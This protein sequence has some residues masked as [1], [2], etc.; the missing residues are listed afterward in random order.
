MDGTK[1]ELVGVLGGSFNPVHMGHMMLASYLTQWGYVDKVWMMLS[2]LNPLKEGRTMLPDLKRM[3]MINMATHNATDIDSCDIEL[4]MPRPS[5]TIDTLDLLSKR[6]PTK[7]FKLIIGS[8]N[9]RIFDRW[10]EHQR[11]L[12]EY[13]V[14]V[15]P[16]SGYP[17]D[18]VYVDGMEVVDAPI[19]NISSTFI[20]D[21][22]ARGKD[23]SFFLPP[24]VF[25]YI[26]ENRFYMPE[27]SKK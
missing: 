24:G 27:Q 13:G 11:I 2:P 22:I 25:K 16:R 9:W 12:D 5:Y 15:Y 18:S 19:V 8:D 7:K 26:R 14:I 17:I 23:M 20:R 1:K 10:R 4:S 3:A 6:H 21:A